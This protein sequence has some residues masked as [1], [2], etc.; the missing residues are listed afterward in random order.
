[1]LVFTACQSAKNE[2]DLYNECNSLMGACLNTEADYCLFGYKWGMDE[3]FSPWE[4]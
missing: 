2:S 3:Y 1:M 4:K